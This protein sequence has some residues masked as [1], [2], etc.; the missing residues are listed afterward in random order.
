[1]KSG[2]SLNTKIA[3][4]AV[5]APRLGERCFGSA[6]F[7]SGDYV[8]V[9]DERLARG[10]Q[11]QHAQ[12]ARRISRNNRGD[13]VDHK[14]TSWENLDFIENVHSCKAPQNKRLTDSGRNV[15]MIRCDVSDFLDDAMA[16]LFCTEAAQWPLIVFALDNRQPGDAVIE[17]GC[18]CNQSR[19]VKSHTHGISEQKVPQLMPVDISLRLRWGDGDASYD[20]IEI[21]TVQRSP[22]ALLL[23]EN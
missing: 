20:R 15:G 12:G 6:A 22:Q 16:D 13:K 8:S 5:P 10:N 14:K 4:R 1:M 18:G 21:I 3:V 23:V 17:H 11:V 7:R 9:L 2:Q 19:I